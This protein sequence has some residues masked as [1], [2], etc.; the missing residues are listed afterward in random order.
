MVIAI[1]AFVAVV[2]VPN[3][4]YPANPPA[5]GN[6]DTIGVRT[7]LFFLMI[8]VSIAALVAAIALAR[9]LAPRFGVWN[10]AIAAG[11]AYVVFIGLVQYLL[12]PI[13]EVPEDIRRWSCGVSVRLRSACT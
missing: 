9:R 4:K 12:P 3:I 13:N 5:V 7:E 10:A 1:A 11:L 8:V 2:I 6:P